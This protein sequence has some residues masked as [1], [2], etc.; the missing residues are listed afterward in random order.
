MNKKKKIENKKAEYRDL[1]KRLE[2]QQVGYW[3]EKYDRQKKSAPSYLYVKV[4]HAIEDFV[5]DAQNENTP[6]S[7]KSNRK[8]KLSHPLEQPTTRRDYFNKLRFDPLWF[9]AGQIQSEKVQVFLEV[10]QNLAS[11]RPKR[12]ID[13]ESSPDTSE[14]FLSM[15]EESIKRNVSVNLGLRL[16]HVFKL[17]K[18]IKDQANS[19]AIQTKI[20]ERNNLALERQI[21]VNEY[22]D[23]CFEV[24]PQLFVVCMDLGYPSV[25]ENGHI[26]PSRLDLPSTQFHWQLFVQHLADNPDI[27]GHFEKLELSA[28]KGYSLH[29]VFLCRGDKKYLEKNWSNLIGQ[30]W[31]RVT[32]GYGAYHNCNPEIRAKFSKSAVGEIKATEKMKREAFQHWVVDYVTLSSQYLLVLVPES[33]RDFSIGKH[34]SPTPKANENSLVSDIYALSEKDIYACWKITVNNLSP[35]LSAA[36][37]DAPIIY[38]EVRLLL[39]NHGKEFLLPSLRFTRIEV[40]LLTKI[41]TLI[42]FIRDSNGLAFDPPKRGHSSPSLLTEKERAGRRTQIGKQIF[43]I[44]RQLQAYSKPNITDHLKFFSI[45]VKIFFEVLNIQNQWQ[46]NSY[47]ILDPIQHEMDLHDEFVRQVRHLL[48]SDIQRIAHLMPSKTSDTPQQHKTIKAVIAEQNR[49]AN[50]FFDKSS[51]YVQGKIKEDV[52]L[53]SLKFFINRGT[54]DIPLEIFSPLFTTFLRFG[55]NRR[56]LYW[57]RGYIRRWECAHPKQLCAHVIFFLNT[58]DVEAWPQINL[59]KQI[60]EYWAK[61]VKEKKPNLKNLDWKNYT[62]L[63]GT[64]ETS[65]IYHS[66]PDLND[67]LVKIQRHEKAKQK[68]FI[69]HVVMHLTKSTLYFD[70]NLIALPKAPIQGHSSR[71]PQK[72]TEPAKTKKSDPKPNAIKTVTGT[73]S[74]VDDESTHEAEVKIAKTVTLPHTTKLLTWVPD[75]ASDQ[76]D[77]MLISIDEPE[78]EPH[79]EQPVAHDQ[80]LPE[81]NPKPHLKGRQM[82]QKGQ[83]YRINKQKMRSKKSSKQD[84]L[85]VQQ[86]PTVADDEV[87]SPHEPELTPSP[88]AQEFA[89]EPSAE[90]ESKVADEDLLEPKP[91]TDLQKKRM[92]MIESAKNMKRF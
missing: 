66:H 25:L 86:S 65:P 44:D 3:T 62:H 90:E 45:N 31:Q 72:T 43:D 50:G 53:L 27:V 82:L 83:E 49:I 51:K 7:E 21:L 48:N 80:A 88:I 8:E 69:R 77:D 67:F 29:G 23:T 14:L 41:E 46:P 79:T 12:I 91:L 40:D 18:T 75:L 37:K 70:P 85:V 5:V 55:Q 28:L 56:P 47:L 34:P 24:Y 15:S 36:L 42:T 87:N 33:S 16:P 11:V 19:H 73:D 13:V 26:R 4:L 64:I 10:H 78:P 30:L 39:E 32:Q 38:N 57:S 81:S 22:V 1:F 84:S 20:R 59:V 54:D 92:E 89:V 2:V 9:F 17:I 74:T 6:L 76:N 52:T 63:Q 61:I 68:N 60:E 58:A 71:D 35:K